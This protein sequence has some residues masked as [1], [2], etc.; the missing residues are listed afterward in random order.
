MDLDKNLFDT[1][2]SLSVVSLLSCRIWPMC[3]FF[4][5]RLPVILARPSRRF[6]MI[7]PSLEGIDENVSRH[8]AQL[9]QT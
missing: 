3:V 4:D 7:G 2:P 9:N 5:R 6:G 8:M 1:S